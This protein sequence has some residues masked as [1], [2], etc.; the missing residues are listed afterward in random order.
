MAKAQDLMGVGMA[1]EEALREGDILGFMVPSTATT[2]GGPNGPTVV[3]VGSGVTS[4]Q[5]I[6][7][8]LSTTEIDRVYTIYNTGSAATI[9]VPVSVGSSNTSL[10]QTSASSFSL[11]SAKTAYVTRLGVIGT[12][13]TTTDRWIYTLS[14]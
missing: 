12:V 2:L 11:T 4:T 8:F 6:L 7:T 14:A 13:N 5:S 10:F 3:E 1:P 9:V